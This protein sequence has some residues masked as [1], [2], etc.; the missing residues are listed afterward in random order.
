M[1]N[2]CSRGMRYLKNG[3]IF[4]PFPVGWGGES[5]IQTFTSNVD[6]SNGQLPLSVRHLLDVRGSVDAP[7]CRR[8]VIQLGMNVLHLQT[9]AVECYNRSIRKS[10]RC[11][12]D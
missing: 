8:I 11:A 4:H 6:R 10:L 2:S 3:T 5:N 12:W 1:L 7:Q 9:L